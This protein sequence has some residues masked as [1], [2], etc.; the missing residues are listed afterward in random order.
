MSATNQFQR[1]IM[2]QFDVAVIGGGNAAL[3]AAI[4]A[5]EKGARVVLVERADR[6]HRGGNSAFT[7]GRFASATRGSR[8]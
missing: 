1:D 6:D 2:E 5:R 7:G 8:T 3:C 4:S